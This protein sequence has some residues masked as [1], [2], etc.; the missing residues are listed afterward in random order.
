M[1][2]GSIIVINEDSIQHI[3][4]LTGQKMDPNFLTVNI[5]Y[6]KPIPHSVV[7]LYADD[8]TITPI[9]LAD[10]GTSHISSFPT[11]YPEYFI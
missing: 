7:Y 10:L 3:G 2:N 9:T 1:T 6:P 11:L 8:L 5:L 4:V